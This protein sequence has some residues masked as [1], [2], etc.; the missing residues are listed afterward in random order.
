[1]LVFWSML[2]GFFYR[3][4]NRSQKVSPTNIFLYS[5]S[6]FKVE[7][8]LTL[9]KITR[10]LRKKNWNDGKM[11]YWNAGLGDLYPLFQHSI[12]PC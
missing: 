7:N 12:I 6:E 10:K 11:E 9:L 8:C 2:G 3:R 5:S 1:M 4:L